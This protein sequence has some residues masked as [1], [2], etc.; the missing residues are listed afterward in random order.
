MKIELKMNGKNFF[1]PS[2]I[3]FYNEDKTEFSL[4]IRYTEDYDYNFIREDLINNFE[5]FEIKGNTFIYSTKE[6]IYIFD[7]KEEFQIIPLNTKFKHG[8]VLLDKN[9][10]ILDMPYLKTTI[11]IN[12]NNNK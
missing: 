11:K 6:N 9:D 3:F 8:I 5:N 2:F 7:L 12:E 1:D 10:K 4:G